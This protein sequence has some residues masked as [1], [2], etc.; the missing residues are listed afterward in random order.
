MTYLELID[1]CPELLAERNAKR[2]YQAQLARHPDP[3][4]PDWPGHAEEPEAEPEPLEALIAFVR[5]QCDLAEK[6]LKAGRR[7]N[8][9]LAMHDADFEI[10]EALGLS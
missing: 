6:H 9:V 8:A 2:R 10:A 4:D 5:G 7:E 1:E 3:R